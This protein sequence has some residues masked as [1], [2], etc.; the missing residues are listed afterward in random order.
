MYMLSTLDILFKEVERAKRLEAYPEEPRMP[1]QWRS[2]NAGKTREEWEKMF[3][4]EA[5]TA[6]PS[7]REYCDA[8]ESKNY[9][10]Q[11]EVYDLK[12]KILELEDRNKK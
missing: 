9:L 3:A 7:M 6:Y 5:L 2:Y 11:E 12:R 8:V 4:R 1:V 10:L